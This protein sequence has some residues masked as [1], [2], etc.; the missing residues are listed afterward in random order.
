MGPEVVAEA[1][2]GGSL[3]EDVCA[4]LSARSLF[5]AASTLATN[6]ALL[7]DADRVLVPMPSEDFAP[8]PVSFGFG[9]ARYFE[10]LCSAFGGHVFGF[11]AGRSYFLGEAAVDEAVAKR[12]LS[13]GGAPVGMFS[14]VSVERTRAH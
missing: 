4:L 3:A 8:G 7:S 14:G 5:L 6:V 11:Q 12:H 1:R 2:L 9:A 10:E 13:A